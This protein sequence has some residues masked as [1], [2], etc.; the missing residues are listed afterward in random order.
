[1]VV[2]RP[3]NRVYD[4]VHGWGTVIAIEEGD[5][6]TDRAR[7]EW[8]E[9]HDL[10]GDDHETSRRPPE[11]DAVLTEDA[12][13]QLVDDNGEIKGVHTKEVTYHVGSAD[14]DR[15]PGEIADA[16]D[17]ILEFG[18]AVKQLRTA[19]DSLELNSYVSESAYESVED[20]LEDLDVLVHEQTEEHK[21]IQHL[22]RDHPDHSEGFVEKCPKCRQEAME[23]AEKR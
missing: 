3:T 12:Y 20:A 16:H 7:V 8:D 4:R 19:A 6:G 15:S 10:S 23:K 5:D 17:Q 2:A 14:E 11:F 9:P 21:Y 18:R 22:Q 1:M 13:D